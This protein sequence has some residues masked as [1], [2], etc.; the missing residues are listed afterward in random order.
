MDLPQHVIRPRKGIPSHVHIDLLVIVHEQIGSFVKVFLF[1]CVFS[2]VGEGFF[3]RLSKVF[4]PCH[5]IQQLR[6]GQ[7]GQ[8]VSFGTSNLIENLFGTDVGDTSTPQCFQGPIRGEAGRHLVLDKDDFRCQVI[9]NTQD[10]GKDGVAGI[11]LAI[12]LVFGHLLHFPKHFQSSQ[13]EIRIDLFQRRRSHIRKPQR[14]IRPRLFSMHRL[15]FFIRRFVHFHR[16]YQRH[17][18]RRIVHCQIKGRTDSTHN[19]DTN[20]IPQLPHVL[21][22]FV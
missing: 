22:V 11:V 13:F 12:G 21:D 17:H 7:I 8:L 14:L 2:N 3:N 5:E 4:D 18:P 20:L 16:L 10:R 19:P 15:V 6:D 1:R 9:T